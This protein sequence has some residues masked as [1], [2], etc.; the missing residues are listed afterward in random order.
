MSD[1]DAFDQRLLKRA[2]VYARLYPSILNRFRASH[3]SG[4]PL[5]RQLA[6]AMTA[7][8]DRSEADRELLLRDEH[9]LSPQEAR[10]VLHLVGGGSVTTCAAT[11]MVAES[12]VRSHLKSIFAKTGIR[13]QAHLPRLLEGHGP[14]DREPPN[15]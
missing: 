8:L 2:Q 12:T 5:V 7:A 9:G 4:Q 13:R 1:D 3:E 10:V 11:L 15:R 6:R 14:T